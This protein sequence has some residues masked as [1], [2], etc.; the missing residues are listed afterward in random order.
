M[1]D[2]WKCILFV[3]GIPACGWLITILITQTI[4]NHF[5]GEP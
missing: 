5:G 1:S 4:A 3:V 2:G